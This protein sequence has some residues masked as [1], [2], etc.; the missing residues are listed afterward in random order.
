MFKLYDENQ[1]LNSEAEFENH[2][3]KITSLLNRRNSQKP[4]N[5]DE[6]TQ[7]SEIDLNKEQSTSTA[8]SVNYI[9]HLLSNNNNTNM[10][11]SEITKSEKIIQ[12]ERIVKNEPTLSNHKG[13]FN[14]GIFFPSIY[15]QN[16]VQ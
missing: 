7:E 2:R 8:N 9:N 3:E 10:P 11:A 13:K 5:N 16:H 4:P 12:N 1:M 15:N 14:K 6:K